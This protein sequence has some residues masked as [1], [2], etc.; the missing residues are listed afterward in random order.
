MNLSSRS[1]PSDADSPPPPKRPPP[2][3]AFA[4][5]DDEGSVAWESGSSSSPSAPAPFAYLSLPSSPLA[6]DLPPPPAAAA[7]LPAAPA[8][9]PK[10]KRRL[11]RPAFAPSTLRAQRQLCAKFPHRA[12]A[13]LSLHCA[14]RLCWLASLLGLSQRASGALARARLLSLCA[15]GGLERELDA[16]MAKLFDA[17]CEHAT[18]A[19]VAF[20]QA[21]F[22]ERLPLPSKRRPSRASPRLPPLARMLPVDPSALSVPALFCTV[23]RSLALR[24]RLVAAVPAPSRADAGP[25]VVAGVAGTLLA[26]LTDPG[27]RLSSGSWL[28]VDPARGLLG[29]PA[30]AEKLLAAAWREHPGKGEVPEEVRGH[31]QYVV[32]VEHDKEGE[33][34]A[35]VDVTRRYARSWSVSE[36]LRGE[37]AAWAGALAGLGGEG[38]AP[39]ERAELEGAR[40][41]PP[42]TKG[43]FKDHPR[44]ALG[45]Q[46]LRD[47]VVRPGAKAQGVVGGERILLREDVSV[48]RN[49]WKWLHEGR[50]VKKEEEGRPAKEVKK[51]PGLKKKGGSVFVGGEAGAKFDGKVGRIGG[52]A[53]GGAF[54]ELK[55][56]TTYLPSVAEQKSEAKQIERAEAEMEMQRKRE[57]VG[58]EVEALYG[59]WQTDPWKPPAVGAS[60]PIP[61]NEHGNVE[62]KLLNPGLVHV[63]LRGGRFA[64]VC[65]S[66][67][68]PYAPCLTAFD[69]QSG[70]PVVEGVVVHERNRELAMDAHANWVRNEQDKFEVGIAR[71]WRGFARRL[72]EGERL[73]KGWKSTGGNRGEFE[74]EEG[75]EEKGG[76]E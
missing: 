57:E 3:A 65:K 62:L 42:K 28:H 66:I 44:Y 25:F 17:P 45:S 58:G 29:S 41:K 38:M 18:R 1:S 33:F 20:L 23:L 60:D 70:R 16:R 12:K 31:A 50:K 4:A 7:A 2:F 74:D 36:S 67:G 32:A 8:P 71:K 37:E 30:A 51:R 46:L 35:A 56:G 63:H 64:K 11:A 52:G 40:E 76:E 54:E 19:G 55:R 49:K 43:A 13:A 15:G 75:A 5:D 59:I 22:A 53:G 27:V 68:V 48:A 73:E 39:K 9:P 26:A 6:L 10:K 14:S 24:A 47:D 61:V 34:V 21:W 72:L 69:F